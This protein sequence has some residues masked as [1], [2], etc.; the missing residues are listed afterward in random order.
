[1]CEE[2]VEWIWTAWGWV[3]GYMLL[4]KGRGDVGHG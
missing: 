1:M 2:G 4:L 3:G